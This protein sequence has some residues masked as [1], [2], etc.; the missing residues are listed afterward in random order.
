[1]IKTDPKN[2]DL[3]KAGFYRMDSLVGAGI[4][5]EEQVSVFDAFDRLYF[6][7]STGKPMAGK[8]LRFFSIGLNGT[9][10]PTNSTPALGITKDEADTNWDL[11]GQ[12]AYG[13]IFQGIAFQ[14]G[15]LQQLDGTPGEVDDLT[16]SIGSL[17]LLLQETSYDLVIND[18]SYDRGKCVHAPAGA[19]LWTGPAMTGTAAAPVL[20]GGV[21][22][23]VPSAQNYKSYSEMPLWMPQNERLKITVKFGKNAHDRPARRPALV[24]HAKAGRAYWSAAGIA[25]L[26]GARRG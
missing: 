9:Y 24:H 1:M 2:I 21:G 3:S 13:Y 5:D 22:N 17:N 19:G 14:I 26:F 7:M 12:S 11:Q 16:Q 25:F 18:Y 4:I 20:R 15:V 10:I 23:G 8:D 6:E